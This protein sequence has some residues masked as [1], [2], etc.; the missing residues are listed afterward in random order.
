VQSSPY[1]R[2]FGFLPIGVLGLLG[3]LA[4]LFFWAIEQ[5]SK[6][7]FSDLAA[8][9]VFAFALFGVL[10]SIY[11][12]YLELAIIRAVCMWCLTSAVIMAILLVLTTGAAVARLVP[13]AET[14]F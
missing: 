13:V 6:G 14:D 7:R 8:I 1:A 3:Y 2:L 9:A 5:F 4:I 11:L 12:T 10:F